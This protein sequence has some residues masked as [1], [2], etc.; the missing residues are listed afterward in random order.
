MQTHRVLQDFLNYTSILVQHTYKILC[1]KQ[2][3]VTSETMV[4][5]MHG[6]V[7]WKSVEMELASPIVRIKSVEME[8][9][10]PI[11]RIHHSFRQIMRVKYWV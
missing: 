11:V 1:W 4:N 2:V 7:H 5:Y 3:Y 10:S 8:L 9:V 6:F